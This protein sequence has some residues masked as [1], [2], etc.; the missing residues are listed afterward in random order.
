[1][2]KVFV[3][4]LFAVFGTYVVN[5]QDDSEREVK[6]EKTEVKS[7][8]TV[9]EKDEVVTAKT[10]KEKDHK[11]YEDRT[12]AG[13]TVDNI[14]HGTVQGIRGAGKGIGNAASWT[15]ENTKH[16]KVTKKIFDQPENAEERQLKIQKKAMKKEHKKA[17]KEGLSETASYQDDDQ[18]VGEK[19]KK[20]VKKGAEETG[21]AASNAWDK[22]KHN[23]VTK[24]VFDQPGDVD[25]K[26]HGSKSTKKEVK[27]KDG[28]TTTTKE[29]KTKVD[30]EGNT[31]VKKKKETSSSN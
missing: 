19:A 8:G 4:V 5:A 10:E 22:T 29:K 27:T 13:Q 3:L 7:D 23:K 14:G 11:S 15:W 25:Q 20:D 12:R 21:D 16:N 28:K 17:E 26:D 9:K 1:M 2:K 30:D 18:H 31:S 6:K 24:E